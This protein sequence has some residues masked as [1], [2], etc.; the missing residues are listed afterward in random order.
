MRVT[1]GEPLTPGTSPTAAA[2]LGAVPLGVSS[3]GEVAQQQS[4]GGGGH[5]KKATASLGASKGSQGAVS[6]GDELSVRHKESSI[7][8]LLVWIPLIEDWCLVQKGGS[9]FS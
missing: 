3:V 2:R 9:F 5:A 6:I 8:I 1:L 4:G 7:Q